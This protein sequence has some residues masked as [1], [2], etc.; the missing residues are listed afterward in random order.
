[1]LAA[2]CVQLLEA[3]PTLRVTLAGQARNTSTHDYRAAP[4]HFLAGHCR[5]E[6]PTRDQGGKASQSKKPPS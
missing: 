3:T 2:A 5:T 6:E 4:L 1:E